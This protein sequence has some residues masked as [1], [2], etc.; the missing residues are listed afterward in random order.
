[1]GLIKLR[2]YILILIFLSDFKTNIQ[3]L[4]SHI[5]PNNF[6][7]IY[8][9]VNSKE[10]LDGQNLENLNLA[11][12]SFKNLSLENLNL[13]EKIAQLFVARIWLV[14]ESRGAIKYNNR[15]KSK[16]KKL[17]KDY[18]IGGIIF[19]GLGNIKEQI[20]L[21]QEFQAISKVPLLIVQDA[22][23][24]LNMR[25]ADV[26]KFPCNLALGAIQDLN[27]IYKLGCEVGKQC[28]IMGVAINLAPVVD[29]NSD[30]NPF[31][32]VRSFGEDKK[33][34]TKRAKAFS[35]GLQDYGIIAC[36]KH[37]PGHGATSTDSH[38]NMPKITKS[39]SDLD[40]F[41]LYP[42][43]KLIRSGIGSIMVGHLDMPALNFDAGATSISY[44][45][46]TKLLKEKLNFNGLI[47]TDALDMSAVTDIFKD[48][49]PGALEFN[50]FLAGS[51][52]LLCSRDIPKAIKFIKNKILDNPELELELDKR[53]LKI[54]TAKNKFQK[55]LEQ[56]QYQNKLAQ[57]KLHANIKDKKSKYKDFIGNIKLYL[58]LKKNL[59]SQK[60][61]SQKISKQDKLDLARDQDKLLEQAR[62][63]STQINSGYAYALQKELYENSVT[64]LK[65]EQNLIPIKQNLSVNKK[66]K[67]A[68]F[69]I[70]QLEKS[71]F[72]RKLEDYYSAD[73]FNITNLLD[74]ADQ[75]EQVEQQLDQ[76]EQKIKS[77]NIN[78]KIMCADKIGNLNRIKNCLNNYDKIIVSI[79]GSHKIKDYGLSQEQIDF[80]NSLIVNQKIILA[81]FTSPYILKLFPNAKSV[82]VGFEQNNITEN[83]LAQVIIGSKSA[84]GKLNFK[85]I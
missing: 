34:V 47:I 17:I 71:N 36:A 31:I 58:D 24:G 19:L 54:L 38:L 28:K 64:I 72:V 30:N 59:L 82:I 18:N 77:T 11:D 46:I 4:E 22:E 73:N 43:K 40:N 76:V 69:Q 3:C 13:E 75:V 45:T 2:F 67:I 62:Y 39:F 10:I 8:K 48:Q 1:M 26:L 15:F 35:L 14:S 65:D 84:L 74:Q 49:K 63:I 70:G 16:I 44:L 60:K 79:F 66:E 68:I 53:V 50:A 81:I 20:S 12:L 78:C 23:R 6:I 32:N 41:D 42:F 9:Q 85:L 37:F 56:D 80:V 57:S 7:D 5:K 52:I 29:I 27:L 83:Y 61:L 21:T 55:L 51:D 33:I 25:L